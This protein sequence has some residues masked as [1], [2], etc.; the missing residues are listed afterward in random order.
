MSVFGKILGLEDGWNWGG[1]GGRVI[2]R[3]IGLLK[4]SGSN[5]YQDAGRCLGGEAVHIS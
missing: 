4:R 1:D 2:G 3:D 5:D